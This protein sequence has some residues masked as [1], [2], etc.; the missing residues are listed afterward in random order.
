MLSL[1]AIRE[2][3]KGLPD[4]APIDIEW[5]NGPPADT[6][7][8]VIINGFEQRKHQNGN[9]LAIL[10]DIKYLDEFITDNEE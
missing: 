2:A 6:D 4:D 10:V 5:T 3:I 9:R 8:A 1:G 7:P